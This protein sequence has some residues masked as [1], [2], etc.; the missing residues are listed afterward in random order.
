[1][2]WQ[3][4]RKKRTTTNSRKFHTSKNKNSLATF[5][6][7]LL[8]LTPWLS[9]LNNTLVKTYGR[10]LLLRT[11]IIFFILLKLKDRT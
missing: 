8:K 4:E 1:M 7:N 11:K 6:S 5:V 9:Y 10:E 3:N 2:T